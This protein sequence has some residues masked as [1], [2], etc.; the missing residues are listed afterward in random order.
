MKK[1][2]IRR[3]LL[4]ILLLA[5][6]PVQA[7]GAGKDTVAVGIQYGFQGTVKSGSCFPLQVKLENMGGDFSGTFQIRVP[8][9][10]E[11]HELSSSIWMRSDNWGSRT[12]RIY[13]Y[14]QD[15]QMKAGEVRED[16]LY[17]ELPVFEGSLYVRI[18]NDEGSV[19]GEQ[20]LNCEFM[21][22]NNRILVGVVSS[23]NIGIEKLDGMQVET[24]QGYHSDAFVKTIEL[25]VEDIYPNP[26][27]LNQ[28][29]ILIADQDAAFTGEQQQALSRW[30]A[31]GGFFL[32]RSGEALDEL[33]Q[34]FLVGDQ[35]EAFHQKLDMMGSY[36]FG[37][38]DISSVPIRK[39]PSMGKY[40]LILSIY[41]LLAGPGLYLF[42]KKK[43]YRKYLWT[44]ICVLS[45]VFM[46][47]IGLLGQKT[48]IY[49]PFISYRGLYEQQG[50]VWSET[51]NL[52]IQAPYNNDYHLYLDNS[53]RLRPANLGSNGG[54]LPE[55][56]TAEQIIIHQG[57]EQNKI[58]IQNLA[59]F[60]QSYFAL[61]KNK[62]LK[63][64]EKVQID[65]TGDG[66]QLEGSIYNPTSYHIKNGILVM[67]NR[68][69]VVGDLEAGERIQM[70]RTRLFSYGN[71]GLDIL[72]K[73]WLDFSRFEF[74][75][76]ERNNLASSAYMDLRMEKSDG[77]YFLGIVENPDLSFQKDSGYHIYGSTLLKIPVQVQWKADG[78]FWCPNLERYG[79]SKIG[80]FSA[81][82]NLMYGKEATVD[83]SMEFMGEVQE[84]IFS[85]VEYDDEKYFFPFQGKVAFYRWDKGE[86]E[87]IQDWETSFDR[88][89]LAPYLSEG[90]V[91][92]VR[93]ILSESVNAKDRSCALPCIRGA[94]KVE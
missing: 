79:E 11:N 56:N 88:E 70:S 37:D 84:L 23:D 54:E 48:N 20:E 71:G 2:N 75:E 82:T 34:S 41:I 9:Q 43:N 24:E 87:E 36:T 64:Q 35:Q 32:R 12:N 26:E 18:L 81:D 61:E 3:G 47:I 15:I 90:Q 52:G 31:Q 21:E 77:M 59:V 93:Y 80:E 17:L 45:V 6:I 74:P 25:A 60:N 5:L 69:A 44:G 85:S 91:L 33:F 53:Y 28:L 94:G 29:D 19:L 10:P 22:N 67:P 30:E 92:R 58:T 57:A 63:E 66:E 72:L 27:A 42:L 1:W 73:K 65:L 49:A 86:F 13:T 38:S 7:Q 78:L 39:K 62:T 4:L 16:V 89:R 50:D 76:Y 8:E 55:G 40:V 83:Y 68:A 14:E 46:G 51:V